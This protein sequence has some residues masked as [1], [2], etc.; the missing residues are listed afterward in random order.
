MNAMEFISPNNIDCSNYTK[1]VSS[2]DIAMK[3]GPTVYRNIS[4][5]AG[6]DTNVVFL[7]RFDKQAALL[8]DN[9]NLVLRVSGYSGDSVDLTFD[10]TGEP[11]IRYDF[12][13][14]EIRNKKGKVKRTRRVRTPIVIDP[15]QN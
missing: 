15:S 8:K 7:T 13:V 1:C 3:I 2:Y 5:Q 14:E 6:D 9:D 12:N 11:H 10:I 4:N